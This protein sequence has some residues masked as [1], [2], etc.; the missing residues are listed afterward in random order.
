MAMATVTPSVLN[1]I[2]GGIEMSVER[3]P[4]SSRARRLRRWRCG[5]TKRNSAANGLGYL[6]N[7][8]KVVEIGIDGRWGVSRH[9][10]LGPEPQKPARVLFDWQLPI[11]RERSVSAETE[12]R[13][14]ALAGPFWQRLRVHGDQILR[15]ECIGCDPS[16]QRKSYMASKNCVGQMPE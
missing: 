2:N 12:T 11:K 1:G 16:Y 5:R 6:R 8:K 7:T 10:G 4:T 9:R 14:G 3:R 15:L 13:V